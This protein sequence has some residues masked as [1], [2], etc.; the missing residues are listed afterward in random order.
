MAAISNRLIFVAIVAVLLAGSD[1][2][3]HKATDPSLI[4]FEGRLLK[5]SPHPGAGC[6]L[7]YDHQV[8]KYHVDRVLSGN[9]IGDEIVV[10][11]PACDDDVF[12]NI[13]L[14]SRVRVTVRIHR[15][16]KVTTNYPGIR[17]GT[18]AV[19]YVAE[20]SSQSAFVPPTK[21]D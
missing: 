15:D 17:E 5:F 14:G 11:H 18:P 8:A 6:G 13:P 12:K 19:W 10:D 2:C 9:Y 3:E 7:L 4:T 1:A 20:S 16:Y 21:I